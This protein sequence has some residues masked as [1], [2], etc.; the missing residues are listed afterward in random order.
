MTQVCPIPNRTSILNALPLDQ[1][2][3]SSEVAFLSALFVH[4]AQLQDCRV[5]ANSRSQKLA[6]LSQKTD[7][8]HRLKDLREKVA[9]KVEIQTVHVEW[10]GTRGVASCPCRESRRAGHSEP[11]VRVSAP[12]PDLSGS[13]CGEGSLGASG[14]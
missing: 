1:N 13:T 4:L 5:L 10:G 12:K 14:R 7:Q 8:E 6:Q 2:A 9:C 3:W 11:E